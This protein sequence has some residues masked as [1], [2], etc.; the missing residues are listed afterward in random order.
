[1]LPSLRY[2]ELPQE[3]IRMQVGSIGFLVF[4]PKSISAVEYSRSLRKSRFSG[5]F[6]SPGEALQICMTE[7]EKSFI[8][9][10]TNAGCILSGAAAPVLSSLLCS[11]AICSSFAK[12]SGIFR[13]WANS[14][15]L[16]L[17]CAS[18][19]SGKYQ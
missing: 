5:A 9:G 1:M 17:A 16:R 19:P 10:R 12:C 18:S 6:I 15:I 14:A 7:A 2:D 8:N 11:A 3:P 4:R 13:I